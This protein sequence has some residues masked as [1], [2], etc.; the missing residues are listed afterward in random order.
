[1]GTAPSVSSRHAMAMM[2]G[3]ARCGAR[4]QISRW[5]S[6]CRAHPLSPGPAWRS[7]SHARV[8]TMAIWLV[9][10][11]PVAFARAAPACPAAA[12]A[13]TAATATMRYA[14]DSDIVRLGRWERIPASLS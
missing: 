2:V 14:A 4:Q 8:R 1:M 5:R 12:W 6:R 7:E 11:A 10:A 3:S 13:A 9:H